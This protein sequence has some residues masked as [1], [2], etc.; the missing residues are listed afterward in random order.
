MNLTPLRPGSRVAVV[1]PSGP[2]LPEHL[3]HG[4][5]ILRDWKLEVDILGA[6]ARH[7]GYLAGTDAHRLNCLNQALS[8]EY[9]AV[10]CARG[11]Y[12]AMRIVHQVVP[13]ASPWLVGFSDITALLLRFYREMPCVHGPVLKS[14]RHQTVGTALLHDLLFNGSLPHQL[15]CE[16]GTPGVARGPIVAANL[17]VLVDCLDMSWFPDLNG[18]ILILEDVGEVDYRLDRLFTALRMSR[19]AQGL[20]GL[21][22]GDFN[23][24][25]GVYVDDA[26]IPAHVRA[27]A[28]EFGI[29]M[30]SG[31]PSGHLS[32]NTPV[33]LGTLS[34][35]DGSTGLV[36][37]R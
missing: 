37:A 35:L 5:R 20:A 33:L 4:L 12:G 1:S 32:R 17:S 19:R 34:E 24:C 27:L 23:A 21:A 10:F 3:E 9:E 22:L 25:G 36:K 11:G 18:A 31:F 6:Y 8:G 13:H 2:V 14:M 28:E 16:P 30:V 15:Q 29:P 7:R 26:R